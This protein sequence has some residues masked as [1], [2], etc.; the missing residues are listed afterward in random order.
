MATFRENAYFAFMLRGKKPKP[1][2]KIKKNLILLKPWWYTIKLN[3]FNKWNSSPLGVIEQD[4]PASS[5]Q[6]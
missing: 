1:K 5:I 2:I 3:G 4:H 6:P